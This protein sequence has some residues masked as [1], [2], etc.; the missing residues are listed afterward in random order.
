MVTSPPRD[1][2]PMK[3]P[4]ALIFDMDGVLV[5]S[6]P[7]HKRA[8]EE[9]F[10]QFGIVLPESVY[11]SYKGRPDATMLPEVLGARGFSAETVAE[12][13]RLKHR[14]FESIKHELR[15]VE[16]AADFVRWA[17]VRY[18]IALATSATT[19]N[20]EV[21]L[22]TL[23]AGDVFRVIVDSSRHK[24][25]KPDP[26]VFQVA[27]RELG[28]EPGDCWIIEDSINGL[29]AAKAA[30]CLAVAVTT[31][32]DRAKV[33]AAGADVVVDSFAELRELL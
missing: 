3:S 4:T 12:I 28:A 32:F 26:E 6:E 8:K 9:A 22:A 24:R 17:A 14:I 11:D 1:S 25:P 30:G 16:G 27:M 19:R 15:A 5:D 23:N 21:V 33:Q 13:S 29:R 7:L 20:R 10:R 18:Q 31:T 2:L